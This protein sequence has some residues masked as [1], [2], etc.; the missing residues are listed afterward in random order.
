[1]NRN[2]TKTYQRLSTVISQDSDLDKN[3]QRKQDSRLLPKRTTK[4][5]QKLALFPG[6]D[7]IDDGSDALPHVRTIQP[8]YLL[9]RL[10]RKWLPRVTAYC[11]AGAF[12]LD[13]INSHIQLVD[14]GFSVP[15][16]YDEALYASYTPSMVNVHHSGI[17]LINLVDP[18]EQFRPVL[19]AQTDPTETDLF[20][21][22][23]VD[24][25]GNP[26]PQ[27]ISYNA[28]A[29]RICSVGECFFFDYGV[30]VIW[31][32][33]EQE[34]KTI[35]RILKPFEDEKLDTEDYLTEEFHFHYNTAAQPRI[36]ND[37]ITLK[38]PVKSQLI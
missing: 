29:K 16:R 26:L 25:F 22:K 38:N 37:V 10:G 1:M 21:E 17:D 24:C 20:F 3:S 32:L 18:V 14:N 35:L 12:R 4:Q 28:L 9:T 11:T 5:S 2:S 15:K 19:E 23:S 27:T 7:L 31:G 30:V 33:T 13:N 8:D 36:Y 6:A 34:E